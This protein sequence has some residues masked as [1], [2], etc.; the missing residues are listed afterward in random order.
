MSADQAGATLRRLHDRHGSTLVVL[1]PSSRVVDPETL[2]VTQSE[3]QSQ[4]LRCLPPGPAEVAAEGSTAVADLRVTTL[5]EDEAWPVDETC[6][7]ELDG[8]VYRIAK[9]DTLKISGVL[10]SRTLYLAKGVGP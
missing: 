1:R 3:P 6:Q 2:A 9:R 10:V 8:E 5:G 4:T 7:V